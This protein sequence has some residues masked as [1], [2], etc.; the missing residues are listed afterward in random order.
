MSSNKFVNYVQTIANDRN[1]I[2]KNIESF[3]MMPHRY[4]LIERFL[5]KDLFN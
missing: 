1:K 4:T 5:K 3:S 2:V